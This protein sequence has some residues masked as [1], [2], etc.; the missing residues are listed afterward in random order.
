M[1][2][3]RNVRVCAGV[4]LV[5]TY[6]CTPW[7]SLTGPSDT[8]AA[9]ELALRQGELSR[10]LALADSGL[11]LAPS[12]ANTEWSWKFRLLRS[13]V[14]LERGDTQSAFEQLSGAPPDGI[15]YQAVRGKHEYLLAKAQRDQ[16][17]LQEAL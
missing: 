10:A 5:V 3:L 2:T 13:D 11:A 9:A 6:A 7:R 8:I 4:A 12:T 17:H 14:L 16:G 1:G 15:A